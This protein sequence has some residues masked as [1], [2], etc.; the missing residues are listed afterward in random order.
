MIDIIIPAYNAHKTIKKTLLSI[1]VQNISKDINV[2]IIDDHSDEPYDYL[3]DEFSKYLN[4]KIERLNKKSGPGVARNRGLEISNSEY[5]MFI[6]SDDE[7]VNCYS[8]EILLREIKDY[9]LAI[10]ILI[11]ELDDGSLD[12]IS[13]HDRCLHAKL[14]KRDIINKYNL[15]FPNLTRH[16]DSAFHELYLMSNPKT[17][18]VDEYVYLYR[19]NHESLTRNKSGYE[20]YHNYELL[21][22]ATKYVIEESL[23]NNFK[24][25]NIESTIT[26]VLV[27]LYYEYQKFYNEEYSDK[28]YEWMK[29]IVMFYKDNISYQDKDELNY[30]LDNYKYNFDGTPYISWEDFIDKASK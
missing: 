2:Y 11:Q 22:E 15:R 16:E 18:L 28:I 26:S 19:F 20:D 25:S 23:K 5:V 14:Y 1:C 3:I 4:L 9:D 10:G 6:D 24:M 27:Y 17:N 12:Y 13:N 30:Y 8:I 7:F 29:L 21:C